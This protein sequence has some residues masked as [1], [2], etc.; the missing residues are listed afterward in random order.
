MAATSTFT[1]ADNSALTLHKHFVGADV[2]AAFEDSAYG[3]RVVLD[4]DSPLAGTLDDS[5]TT[6]A[7][8]GYTL[9]RRPG[10]SKIFRFSYVLTGVTYLVDIPYEDIKAI[11]QINVNE[12]L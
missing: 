9:S 6:G 1:V 3:A 5:W 2:P 11:E 12:G 8:L 10:K 7:Y 4:D